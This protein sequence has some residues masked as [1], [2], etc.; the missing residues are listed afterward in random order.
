MQARRGL[1]AAHR[2]DGPSQA[3]PRQQDVRGQ[4]HEVLGGGGARELPP[5][6]GGDGEQ[7]VGRPSAGGTG[8]VAGVALVASPGVVHV[9]GFAAAA[10]AAP[11]F[12]FVVFAVAVANFVVVVLAAAAAPVVVF[13]ATTVDVAGAAGA[14]A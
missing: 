6:D 1:P 3:V 13:A 11:V 9:V 14:T 10:A 7:T 2:S 12:V 8:V 4:A 5:D